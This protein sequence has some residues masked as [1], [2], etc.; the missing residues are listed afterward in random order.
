MK[1]A[2][3]NSTIGPTAQ[4]VAV[5]V[6]PRTLTDTEIQ[7]ATSDLLGYPNARMPGGAAFFLDFRDQ[8]CWNGVSMSN[9]V[10]LSGKG[11]PTTTAGTPT[12]RGLPWPM[13]DLDRF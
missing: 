4:N 3:S 10:D 11:I 6:Y 1:T 8:R 13:Q 12:P 5:A 9:I 7:A 2:T